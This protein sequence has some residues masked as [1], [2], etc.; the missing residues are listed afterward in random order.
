MRNSL[1]KNES[2]MKNETNSGRKGARKKIGV[3]YLI[4]KFGGGDGKGPSDRHGEEE[5]ESEEKIGKN[6]PGLGG[7]R[8]RCQSSK[9]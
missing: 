5:S 3:K 6:W 1:D 9:S 8:R 7:N 4:E 2:V